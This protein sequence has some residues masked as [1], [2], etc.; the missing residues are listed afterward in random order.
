V[1]VLSETGMPLVPILTLHG[2]G[3]T[4]GV[5]VCPVSD[6]QEQSSMH[7]VACVCM[8]NDCDVESRRVQQLC[9]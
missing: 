8:T 9:S 3:L 1:A 6:H 5:H 7:Q 4:A 2:L